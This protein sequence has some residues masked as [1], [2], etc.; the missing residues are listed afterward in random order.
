[1]LASCVLYLKMIVHRVYI[2]YTVYTNS[3]KL[4]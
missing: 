1:L 3:D 4:L 2:R